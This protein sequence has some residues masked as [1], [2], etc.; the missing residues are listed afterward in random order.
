MHDVCLRNGLQPRAWLRWAPAVALAAAATLAIRVNAE[1]LARLN[2]TSFT[3]QADTTRPQVGVPFHIMFTMHVEQNVARLQ[4]VVLPPFGPLQIQ[5]DEQHFT[6]TSNGTDY[7]DIVTVVSPQT[8]RIS[9]AGA[10]MDAIDARD[11]KAKRFLSTTP[12]GKDTLE[13]D[14]VGGAS[15]PLAIDEAPRLLGALF[16]VLSFALGIGVI[17]LLAALVLLRRR[18]A[19]PITAPL[20]EPIHEEPI[21]AP[22]VPL[23]DLPAQLRAQP[24]REMALRARSALWESVGASEGETL[25]DVLLNPTV[26]RE[27]SL[28]AVLR[29]AE[30]AAFTHEHDLSTALHEFVRSLE[31]YV[32]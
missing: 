32:A 6:S 4:N 21:A 22:S 11:G 12:R 29:A 31:G 27:P 13:L 7:R 19:V 5:G 18:P 14:V 1:Q 24:T 16:R 26:A 25:N 9:I 20:T 28:R 2:V 8:G 30:R 3:M 10:Y 15:E 23:A 17:A